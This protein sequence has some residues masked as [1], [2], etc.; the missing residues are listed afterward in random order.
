[1][2]MMKRWL[3]DLSVE[4]GFDGAITDEVM[5]EGARRMNENTEDFDDSGVTEEGEAEAEHG[6]VE[7]ATCAG[8]STDF[9]YT[10]SEHKTVPD[11][12]KSCATVALEEGL[13]AYAGYVTSPDP[14]YY[15]STFRTA[16][17]FPTETP[18]VVDEGD[19]SAWVVE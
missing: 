16:V 9:C 3:E 14:P 19:L 12:C 10:T 13:T 17:P 15:V 7:V 5:A 18:N 1:M 6:E 11:L 2:S 8:C 4:M